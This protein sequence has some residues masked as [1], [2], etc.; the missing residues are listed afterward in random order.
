MLWPAKEGILK[1]DIQIEQWP[2]DRLIPYI[3]NARTHSDEQIAQ[4]AASI[5]EF[6]WTNPILVGADG[7]I[8]AGHARLLAARKLKM[9]E[10][11]VIVLDHLSETQRRALVLADNRLALSAGWDE[12]M[13]R[14]ELEALKE[15]A[16]DIDLVGFTDEE[17]DEIL[18]DP[19][20]TNEGLTDEDVVPEPEVAVVT[21]PGDVWILGE[22]RLLCGD[23]TVLTDTEKVL[24][25]GLAD[26]V[27]C[28]PPYNVNYGATKRKIANDNLGDD[29]EKFL[30]DACVN[31]L[32]VTKGAIYVCMSSS[33]I[34]TLQR[35]FREAGG[36][37]STFVVWAKNTFTMGR[38]V[39]QRQYEPILYGWKEGTDHFW[40]GARDQGDIWFIKKPH[41]NDLHP[42]MK[43]VELVERAIRNSSKGRD[44]VLDP[45]GGSGTTLIACEKSGR[46]ARVVELEPKYCDVICRR[47]QAFSGKTATLEADGRTFADVEAER[48]GV[49]A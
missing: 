24:A 5:V 26:M 19:E 45:F 28:D 36:H 34:H 10:V 39:Y 2:I 15:D 9:L 31:M 22:H 12:D 7:V 6:G 30:R 3:R 11:P 20:G 33:E 43:P 41:V 46:Q 47:F 14:V 35:V 23:A 27:F 17:L 25:G 16:F 38:S 42:T 13:L 21:V 29:F 4:V 48:L 40:C 1:T 49:P 8:I 37:W 18:A 44:T 32:A